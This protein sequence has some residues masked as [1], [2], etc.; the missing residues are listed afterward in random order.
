MTRTALRSAICERKTTIAFLTRAAYERTALWTAA[1]LRWSLL[2]NYLYTTH[3]K[4]HS[5]SRTIATARHASAATFRLQI[6]HKLLQAHCAHRFCH[7]G[8][9]KIATASNL[10]PVPGRKITSPFFFGALLE[11][12]KILPA[13]TF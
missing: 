1:H 4:G 5:G 8:H 10:P 6:I 11:T 7:G 3:A 12:P 13:G 9:C 2:T